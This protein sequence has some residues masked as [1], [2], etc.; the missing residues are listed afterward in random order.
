[1]FRIRWRPLDGWRRFFGEVGIIILGVMVALGLGAVATEIGWRNEVARTRDA[2]TL[3]FGEAIGQGRDNVHTAP[4]VERRLDEL[5]RIV[6]EADRTGRLPPLGPIGSPP[7]WTWDSGVWDSA[8]AAQT[9]SHFPRDEVDGIVGFYG[10][11]AILRDNTARELNAWSRLYALVG[12]GRPIAPGEAERLYTAIRDARI[13]RRLITLAAIRAEQM[14]GLYS[15]EYDRAEAKQYTVRPIAT[16]AICKPIANEVPTDYGEAP[17][18]GVIERS[19]A[20]PLTR[21]DTSR[22]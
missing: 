6:A 20:N 18:K 5:A 16:L 21:P 15:L 14:A 12:P 2:L 13:A 7:W 1:M 11:V 19:R 10:F 22:R 17:M 3:E 8:V 9:A 4:C